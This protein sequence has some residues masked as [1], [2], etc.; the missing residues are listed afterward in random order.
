MD[1]TVTSG[2]AEMSKK[3]VLVSIYTLCCVV[4]AWGF[5][6]WF[7]SSSAITVRATYLDNLS[8]ACRLTAQR[9]SLLPTSRRVLS[10]TCRSVRAFAFA[11]A[12]LRRSDVC[13]AMVLWHT[14]WCRLDNLNLERSQFKVSIVD[15]KVI[16]E[17]VI[18]L[19]NGF[20]TTVREKVEFEAMQEK[21]MAAMA[22]TM[23]I[24]IKPAK[25]A[26]KIKPNEPCPCGSGKKFKKCTN[27]PYKNGTLDQ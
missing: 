3:C 22:K 21:N 9:L 11:F 14:L 10:D 23:G 20:T 5:S 2:F 18:R 12:A 16:Q 15:D 7:P 6:L 4:A 26:A 1:D 13:Y 8:G 17:P 25:K 24:T 19:P 27:C